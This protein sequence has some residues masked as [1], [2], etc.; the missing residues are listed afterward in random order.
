MGDR[1]DR[2]DRR[3]HTKDPLQAVGMVVLPVLLAHQDPTVVDRRRITMVMLTVMPETLMLM[4]ATVVLG[5]CSHRRSH[6]PNGLLHP[7]ASRR[8][9]LHLMEQ[10]QGL[11][12]GI[13][14]RLITKVGAWGQIRTREEDRGSPVLVL[15]D[16][17]PGRTER[18]GAART[19]GPRVKQP[20][21]RVLCSRD[22]HLPRL[23]RATAPR[24]VNSPETTKA[25]L[26][27]LFLRRILIPTDI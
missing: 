1:G 4:T 10:G 6:N 2:R 13:H 26:S 8:D 24:K 3:I 20:A 14:Q 21:F 16:L 27:R 12:V 19:P 22:L 7:T 11:P 5:R 9:P 15:A 25:R 23:T 18:G 17:S